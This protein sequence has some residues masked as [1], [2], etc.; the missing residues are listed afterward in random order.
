MVLCE[1]TPLT[2]NI[3]YFEGVAIVVTYSPWIRTGRSSLIIYIP[4]C[5]AKWRVLPDKLAVFL[6]KRE[7][8]PWSVVVVH[9]RIIDFQFLNVRPVNAFVEELAAQVPITVC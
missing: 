4:D 5:V 9:V 3:L 2:T 1:Y 6:N 7:A 8:W